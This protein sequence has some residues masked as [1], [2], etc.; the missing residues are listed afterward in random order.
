MRS[1]W[2]R[3]PFTYVALVFALACAVGATWD[4]PCTDSW[5]NDEVSPRASMLGA[6]FETWTPG[7]YFRYPPLHVLG[8]T[9][10][11]SP[12]IL[13]GVLRAGAD[14][15]AIEAELIQ[16]GYMTI[17][18]I[19]GRLVSFAMA[20]GFVWNVRRLFARLG[21]ER[22]GLFAA[23]STALNGIFV[24]FA[25]VASVDVPYLFWSSMALVELDRVAEGEARERRAAIFVALAMLTKDQSAMLL[26]GPL[27]L[28]LFVRPLFAAKSGARLRALFSP[29]VVRAALIAIAI[30]LVGSGAVTNPSGFGQKIRFMTGGGNAGWIVYERNF[31]GTLAQL[32]DI[33]RAAPLFATRAAFVLALCGV[34]LALR[35]RDRSLA[36]RRA[37]PVSAVA[38]YFVLF[39]LPSRWAMERHLMP[40]ALLL[41]PYA[42][43]AIEALRVRG[44]PRLVWALASV[45]L[46]VPQLVDVA[47]V[48]GTLLVDPRN[49]V[50]ARLEELPRGTKVAVLGG[51]QYLPNLPAGLALVRVGTEPLGD[52]SSL[53]GVREVVAPYS[54][55]LAEDPDYIVV[56][57]PFAE[58][59]LPS[60][61]PRSDRQK[62]LE[63]DTDAAGFFS[64]LAAERGQY[65]F[66]VRA[67]CTLPWPLTCRRMH[68]STGEGAWLFAR[69]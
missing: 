68:L 28:V 39:V 50:T 52:R 37:V 62:A 29:A 36:L 3:D 23:A 60:D 7:H 44:R 11:Q 55:V 6:V 33:V 1:R 16:P 43:F 8:L 5:S 65:H 48:D 56:G 24:Y 53:P 13:V 35:G 32:A 25:H 61:R 49:A 21:G 2:V 42:G 40:L 46:L 69:R 66:E 14:R 59:Y 9:V 26:A 19:I 15:A 10:V 22:V 27:L 4:I 34:V 54:N 51:N 45:A 58:G 31:S 47:S 41:I 20:L 67:E 57:Q 63:A 38:S 17:A 30:Y 18:A 64:D 12:L